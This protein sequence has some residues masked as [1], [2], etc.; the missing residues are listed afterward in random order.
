MFLKKGVTD[1]AGATDITG[2]FGSAGIAGVGLAITE[3]VFLDLDIFL[4]IA[5]Q[6]SIFKMLK[7]NELQKN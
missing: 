4:F 6:N 3:F 7:Y 2:A 1:A 5:Y